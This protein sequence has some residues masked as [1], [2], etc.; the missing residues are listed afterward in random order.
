MKLGMLALLLGFAGNAVASGVLLEAET[1]ANCGGWKT[2]TQFV[3]CMG[4]AYLIAHGIGIPVADAVHSLTLPHA[5]AWRV[6]VRTRDWTP[7]YEGEKPG[8]FRLAVNGQSLPSVLGVTPATWGWADAGTFTCANAEV[9]L[10]LQDMTGFDGRCDAIYLTDDLTATAPPA[11][12]PELAAWRAQMFGE[13]EAPATTLDGFDLVVVGGGIAGTCAAIAAA[14]EDMRVA[15]IQDRPMLGGNASDEIR[16]KTQGEERHRIVTAVKNWKSNGNPQQDADTNRLSQVNLHTNIACFTGYRAY[17]VVTNG[18]GLIE[19]VDARAVSSGRRY[20]FCAP[21]VVDSTGDGWV[22]YWA[23]ADYHMGREAKSEFGESY[24][25]D[26]ADASTMGCSMLW[27]SALG[28]EA[29]AFPDVPWALP[30]SGTRSATSGDWTWETGLGVSEN[31]IYDAEMLRDR[32]LRAVYGSFSNAKKKAENANR[33][34]TWVPFNAG[35]RESRRIVGEYF[36]KQDDVVN[37]VYFD[38]AVASATW[39]IDLHYYNGNSG[40]IAGTHQYSVPKW[41][42]PYRALICRDVRNLFLAGRCASLTHVAMGSSRVMNTCGQM[43]VAVGYAASLC[44]KYGCLP[45]DIYCVP[46]RTRELQGLIG[47]SWPEEAEEDDDIPEFSV[48]I[49][50]EDTLHTQLSGTWIVST[51]ASPNNYY[52]ANYYVNKSNGRSEHSENTWFAF[53]PSLPEKGLYEIELLWNS[54]SARATNAPVEIVAMDGVVTQRVDMTAN[55]GTFRS[56]G[57]WSFDPN[58]ETQPM[59]RL[60]TVSAASTQAG[61]AYVIADAVRVTRSYDTIV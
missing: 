33:Y 51:S 27:T 17:G 5:G 20:R 14:E 36:V 46:E 18:A 4:S 13:A 42:I 30:V 54:S 47:G 56:L 38:D 15:L 21:Y 6:W 28:E 49:D 7:D 52:A 2:D 31:T 8:R 53:L 23:G 50:N 44:K 39:P 12:G 37:S 10:Q 25:P 41:Y 22:A 55:G 40:Y 26:T 16:V 34:L 48:V 45:R 43:G 32:L 24:A 9:E 59:I 19:A 58:S 11:E 3:D 61:S 57:R 60:L 35:R 1:F 29:I